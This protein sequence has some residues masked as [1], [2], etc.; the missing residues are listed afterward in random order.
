LS[1]DRDQEALK[2][3]VSC[4]EQKVFALA[5]HLI[6][7]DRNKTYEIAASAFAE[8]IQKLPPS[9]PTGSFLTAAAAKV[10]EKS[11][12]AKAMPSSDEIGLTGVADQEKGILRIVTQALRT[13]SFDEKALVL[14]RDQLHLP[15]KD[16]AAIFKTSEKN[17]RSQTVQARDQLRK[18]IEEWA[19]HK[20]NLTD[21]M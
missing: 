5:L 7:G 10:V 17:A 9:Q 6:G 19:H 2:Q 11:R 12:T 1:D 20:D 14:L 4:C 3:L 13:L 18:K 16:I 15:Y 8:A 21:G